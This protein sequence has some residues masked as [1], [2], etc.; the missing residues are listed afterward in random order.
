MEAIPYLA[1]LSAL[2]GLGLAGYYYTSVKAASPGNDRMVFLMTE[3]QKGAKAFLKKEYQWVS[4]FVVAM[5]V[6]LADR[7]HSIGS[8]QLR[9]RCDP[10]GD[11]RLRRHDGRHD[12]QRPNDRGRQAWSG[13]GVAGRL[14]WWCRDGLHRRRTGPA[15]I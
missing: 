9:A 7:H 14:P 12:G 11:C 3:I 1:A 15:R 5:M 10:V 13:E 4:V 8:G 6:L 2:A